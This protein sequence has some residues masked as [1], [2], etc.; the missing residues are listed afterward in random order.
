MRDLSIRIQW[1][2]VHIPY[3]LITAIQ[4]YYSEKQWKNNFGYAI[5]V[6]FPIHISNCKKNYWLKLGRIIILKNPMKQPAGFGHTAQ[7]CILWYPNIAMENPLQKI[8]HVV[9]H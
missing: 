7:S 2:T 8:G 1:S 5:Q 4:L 9:T 6:E 3:W